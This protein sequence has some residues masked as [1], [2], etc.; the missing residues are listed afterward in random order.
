[1]IS[2]TNPAALVARDALDSK[3][4]MREALNGLEPVLQEHRRL[5]PAADFCTCG[6]T[7]RLVQA[8]SQSITALSSQIGHR[9][10]EAV[11]VAMGSRAFLPS[12]E[13]PRPPS[14]YSCK[15]L[16]FVDPICKSCRAE[17]R[18]R[19]TPLS[20]PQLRAAK[21]APVTRR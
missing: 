18:R 17:S 5:A 6:G 14:E 13:Q 20:A 1:M 10:I 12:C 11:A 7:P 8:L 4:A 3:H 9:R 21:N 2:V 15:G 16:G 19:G